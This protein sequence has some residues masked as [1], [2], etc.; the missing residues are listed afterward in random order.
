MRFTNKAFI[1]ASTILS[2]AGAA[3]AQ[4][5]WGGGMD[6]GSASW[7]DW[8]NGQNLVGLFGTPIVVGD[9]FYFTPANFVANAVNGA[10]SHVTDSFEV[11]LLVHAGFKF[12]GIHVAEYGDYTMTSS[13]PGSPVPNSVSS[14]ALLATSEIGGLGRVVNTPLAFPGLPIASTTSLSNTW[15]GSGDQNLAVL[16]SGTPFTAIHIRVTNDLIA[17][18][19][20]NGMAAEIRKTVFGGQM[21]VTIVPAPGA[22][23]LLG[24]A[25][26]LV[27]RRRRQA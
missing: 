22:A 8:Q 1:A 2:L 6:H 18:S 17:I 25:G 4:I 20:G 9:T 5:A 11:D 23:G 13:N 3:S 16:E 12:D 7:F 15:S 26:L 21:A 14:A 10:T 27:S 24:L 19:G